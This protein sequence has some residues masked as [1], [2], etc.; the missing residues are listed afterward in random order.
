MSIENF[1]E[2][3]YESIFFLFIANI[4]GDSW[5]IK[6]FCE[7]SYENILWRSYENILWNA[8]L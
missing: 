7:M 3:S 1:C 5:V 2:I 4:S 6:I 8:H